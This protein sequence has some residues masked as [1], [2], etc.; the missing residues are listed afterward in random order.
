MNYLNEVQKGMDLL[1]AHQDTIFVGQAMT[2]K[3][4]AVSHQVKNYPLEKRLEFPVA[5]DMQAGFSLGLSLKGYIPVCVYP[6]FDFAILACN[7]IFNHI[8]AWPLLCPNSKVKVIIKILVGA[9]KPLDGGVQHTQNY[10][11]AF[12][13]MSK[14]IQVFDLW[15]P[16]RIYQAYDIALNRT[17]N[18]STILVE[19]TQLY[20]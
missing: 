1:A 14:T 9:K 20:G 12:K 7:Q 8:D 6:R 11:E 15:Y 13:S 16:E 17:D 5:E 3:G 2:C 4:H 18:K 10:A 19:Y